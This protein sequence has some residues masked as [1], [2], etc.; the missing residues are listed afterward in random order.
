MF[1]RHGRG[2]QTW[3]AYVED[4]NLWGAPLPLPSSL[5]VIGTTKRC[6]V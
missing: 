4:L 5:V 2:G 3:I 6:L 1:S